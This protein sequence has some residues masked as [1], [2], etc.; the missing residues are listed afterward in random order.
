MTTRRRRIM[1]EL[2]IEYELV[3]SHLSWLDERA[4]I[5]DQLE[6]CKYVIDKTIKFIKEGEM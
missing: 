4:K 6:E 3:R 5:L 2:N 1:G